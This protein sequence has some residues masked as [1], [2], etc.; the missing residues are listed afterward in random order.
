MYQYLT[1]TLGPPDEAKIYMTLTLTCQMICQL[2][3]HWHQQYHLQLSPL[4]QQFHRHQGQL[5]LEEQ[6]LRRKQQ[7]RRSRSR[8]ISIGY[9][10]NAVHLTNR[11]TEVD[12]AQ[13]HAAPVRSAA[14]SPKSYDQDVGHTHQETVITQNTCSITQAQPS[15]TMFGFASNVYHMCAL[16]RRKST[17]HR[18]L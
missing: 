2:F 7:L 17:K 4:D 14:W 16:S 15:F 9:H 13:R 18:R 3:N 5:H 12:P 6:P 10:V 1:M 8:G 11:T